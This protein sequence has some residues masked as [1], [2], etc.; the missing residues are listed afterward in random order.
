MTEPEPDLPPVSG[1]LAGTS[2][3]TL[4]EPNKGEPDLIVTA[5]PDAAAQEAAER[6]GA[7]LIAAVKRRGRADFCT[8]GG[9]TPIPIRFDRWIRSNDSARTA[10][11]P[12]SDVPLAAQSREEPQPYSLPARISS[13]T[14]SCWYSMEAS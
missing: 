4:P 13:G 3:A 7:S 2:A 12:S 1:A 8:T 5:S 10:R 14:P 11:T 6:I 9:S